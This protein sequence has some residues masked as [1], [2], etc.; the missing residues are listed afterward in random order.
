MANIQIRPAAV[1]DAAGIAQVHVQ[2]WRESYNGIVPESYLAGLDV[3]ERTRRWQDSFAQAKPPWSTSVAVSGTAG[4]EILG[5]V[6]LGAAREDF[7]GFAGEL[8]ALYLLQ[9]AQGAGAGRQLF[10]T[11]RQS[12]KSC[13]INS[14]YLWVLADNPTAGFYRHMGGREIRRKMLEIGGK[15]L[16]EIAYGWEAL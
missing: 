4:D 8:Y 9:A 5:F 6:S 3:A 11:A 13:G 12:L 1:A 10:D 7:N 14:M 2:S 15:E 16:E